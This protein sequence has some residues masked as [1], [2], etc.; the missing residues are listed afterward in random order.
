MK[1]LGIALFILLILV[2]GLYAAKNVI[3][4]IALARAVHAMTGLTVDVRSIDLGV[5][6]TDADARGLRLN[7]PQGFPEGRMLVM[8]RLYVNYRLGDLLRGKI[9][10]KKL[11][12]DIDE[13]TVVK[14]RDGKV[15]V[16]ALKTVKAEKEERPES[17]GGEAPQLQIDEFILEIGT[18]T[19][20]DYSQGQTPYTEK[21][22]LDLKERYTNV[23]DPKKLTGLILAR[24]LTKTDI[25]QLAEFQMQ[26][27]TDAAGNL[28][29][30]VGSAAAEGVKE[31]G[32]QAGEAVEET[33][34]T[35]KGMLPEEKKSDQ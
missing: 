1:K 6:A 2:V 34:D 29:N 35:L 22:R 24:A 7:N 19:Y 28:L 17:A 11:R 27:L 15:N 25:P 8:P 30:Q 13:L 26:L 20:T 4:E 12:L 14:N 5:F 16:M 3:A 32:E 23:N 33:L 9:S 31:A 21:F 10:L 18:V